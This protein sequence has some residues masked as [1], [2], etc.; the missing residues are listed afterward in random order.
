MSQYLESH[1]KD[2]KCYLSQ[3]RHEYHFI[4]KSHMLKFSLRIC[5]F[6]YRQRGFRLIHINVLYSIKMGKNN[7]IKY[8]GN[9]RI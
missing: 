6:R 4:Y 7:F 1:V 8:D 9:G 3:K 5:D 2:Q